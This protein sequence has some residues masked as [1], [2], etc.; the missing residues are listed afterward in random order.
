MAIKPHAALI[1]RVYKDGFFAGR[2]AA[3]DEVDELFDYWRGLRPI[4]A[5][6]KV[7]K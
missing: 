2:D 6:P 1:K 7:R 4:V 5:Y 3:F